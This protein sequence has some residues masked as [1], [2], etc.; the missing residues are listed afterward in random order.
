MLGAEAVFE[1][2]CCGWPVGHA[3]GTGE[4]LSIEP[5]G[6]DNWWLRIRAPE[7]MLRYLVFKGSVAIDGISLTIAGVEEDVV[8]ITVIP[9]TYRGTVLHL[10]RPGD[11]VNIE[12]DI[13]AKYV[14]R[15]L[16]AMERPSRLSV[17]KLREMGY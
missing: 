11:R 10:K 5:L 16:G 1:A 3:D 14:E 15:M 13:L 7:E 9:L 6:D 17:E 8:A 12:C 2:N 4:L